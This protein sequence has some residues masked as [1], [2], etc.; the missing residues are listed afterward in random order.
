[1]TWFSAQ[2]KDASS[3][4]TF[5]APGLSATGQALYTEIEGDPYVLTVVGTGSFSASVY[6]VSPVD[7]AVPVTINTPSGQ[8][9]IVNLTIPGTTNYQMGYSIYDKVLISVAS[10]SY[11][12]Q[13]GTVKTCVEMVPIG[14]E[15]KFCVPYG[16]AIAFKQ[17]PTGFYA[18][19]KDGGLGYLSTRNDGSIAFAEVGVHTTPL[20]AGLFSI[21]YS[22]FLSR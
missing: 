15:P 1:M 22:R 8:A 18:A 16:Q 10:N 14:A 6:G 12:W 7:A 9:G 3:A 5:Y 13:Y 21:I 4:T 19:T 20:M 17:Y 2:V 11:A